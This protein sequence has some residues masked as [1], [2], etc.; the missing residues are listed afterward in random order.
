[1]LSIFLISNL[2]LFRVWHRWDIYSTSYSVVYSHRNCV[3]WIVRLMFAELQ[4]DHSFSRS[5]ICTV[6]IV[7]IQKLSLTVLK[8]FVSLS[9]MPQLL[10]L[11]RFGI[12]WCATLVCV[13]LSA[14]SL[15]HK[16][17]AQCIYIWLAGWLATIAT[18][19][20]TMGVDNTNWW[21]IQ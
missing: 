16:P 19:I 18:V 20:F 12:S 4:F 2:M 13:C 17:L 9:P 21:Q 14:L 15:W 6:W 10:T 7:C 1:M 3:H 11:C 5:F 8:V